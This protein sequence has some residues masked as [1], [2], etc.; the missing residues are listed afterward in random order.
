MTTRREAKRSA[1]SIELH[2]PKTVEGAV[3][4]VLALLTP[5]AKDKVRAYADREEF[6]IG[7]L[8]NDNYNDALTTTTLPHEF[9]VG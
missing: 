3:Q 7:A 8:V 9:G 1:E 6:C 4:V 2:H 5:E